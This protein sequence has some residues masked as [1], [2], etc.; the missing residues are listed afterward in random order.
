MGER[1]PCGSRKPFAVCCGLF[2]TGD[3]IAPTA[4]ALM[5]SRYTAFCK[6]AANYLVQTRHASTRQPDDKAAIEQTMQAVEWVNLVVIAKQKGTRHD[7]TGVVE[8][9]AAC[10]PRQGLPLALEGETKLSQSQLHERSRFVK[11]KGQWL[12][13]GGDILAD[14]IPKHSEPC[15]CGSGRLFKQCHAKANAWN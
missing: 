12:Y 4:E 13:I 3:K 6:G 8:F 10:R 1:C 9:V 7:K 11:E 15:W 14:Y 2:L 5:R